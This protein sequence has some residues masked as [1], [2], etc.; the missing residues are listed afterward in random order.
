MGFSE[1]T[2]DGHDLLTMKGGLV[3]PG[4][5]VWGC[6][7]AE[8]YHHFCIER[9]DRLG[10]VWWYP[11]GFRWFPTTSAGV[12]AVWGQLRPTSIAA[13]QMEQ[14]KQMPGNFDW[15]PANGTQ[16]LNS[17]GAGYGMIAG[18][19]SLKLP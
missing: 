6:G 15:N 13:I 3:A 7:D 11:N 4:I 2:A 9:R 17:Q 14:L 19:F 12:G 5:T 1:F 16:I 10:P 8:P 18:W